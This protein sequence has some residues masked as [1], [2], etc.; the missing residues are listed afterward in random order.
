MPI[1]PCC[2][3][4]YRIVPRHARSCIWCYIRHWPSQ[5]PRPSQPSSDCNHRNRRNDPVPRFV[6]GSH[7]RVFGSPP[8]GRRPLQQP[9]TTTR[10]NA[11]GPN[12]LLSAPYVVTSVRLR[13]ACGV[14]ATRSACCS[15]YSLLYQ[16][17]GANGWYNWT[18][19]CSH[20]ARK[21]RRSSTFTLISSRTRRNSERSPGSM[22]GGSVFHPTPCAQRDR[23]ASA[24][25]VRWQH[26]ETGG[27]QRVG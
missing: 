1:V 6:V 20:S 9:S 18:W 19:A 21:S 3:L 2:R 27:Q 8:T 11:P 24:V 25:V 22:A 13:L 4:W 16:Q 12:Q 10:T 17:H 7:A 5:P 15:L 26:G 14:T 23:A